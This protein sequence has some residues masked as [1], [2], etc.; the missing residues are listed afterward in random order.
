MMASVLPFIGGI[1]TARADEVKSLNEKSKSDLDMAR[2]N[3]KEAND[4]KKK[5]EKNL[6]IAKQAAA[7][8]LE[9]KKS[10]EDKLAKVEDNIKNNEKIIEKDSEIKKI[11]KEIEALGE[12]INQA[13]KEAKEAQGKVKQAEKAY[14]EAKTQS[15]DGEKFIPEDKREELKKQYED[16]DSLLTESKKSGKGIQQ[17]LDE[18]HEALK[19]LEN[20]KAGINGVFDEF[21]NSK[22]Y[23]DK[24]TSQE[25]QNFKNSK[26]S[27]IEQIDKD[28]ENIK[29][30]SEDYKRS[31]QSIGENIER[32]QKERDQKLK[33]YEKHKQAQEIQELFENDKSKNIDD[34][35]QEKQKEKLEAE[36][37]LGEAKGKT[38]QGLA[39]YQG[40]LSEED[41]KKSNIVKANAAA[42]FLE[43]RLKDNNDPFVTQNK[44][45]LISEKNI[46]QDKAKYFQSIL[47]DIEK[48]KEKKENTLEKL[49]TRESELQEDYDNKVRSLEIAR[50]LKAFLENKKNGKTKDDRLKK[51]EEV[52]KQAK[53]DLKK[54][55]AAMDELSKKDNELIVKKGKL[56]DPVDQ[57][58]LE[59]AKAQLEKDMAEVEKIKANIKELENSKELVEVKNLENKIRDLDKKIKDIKNHIFNLENPRNQDNSTRP[60]HR[61]EGSRDKNISDDLGIDLS[62]LSLEKMDKKIRLKNSYLRLK[63]SVNR[64]KEVVT[65]AENYAKTGKM[66]A[67]KRAKLIK[68][69]EKLKVNIGLVEK[70]LV[71][72]EA[73]L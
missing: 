12:Q 67:N 8:K 53:A 35:I 26:N 65:L 17:T 54:K 64:A 71:K 39:E 24:T 63:A 15:P 13:E 34:F 28:I 36:K 58:A 29:K 33:A 9:E 68:L 72:M 31:L 52:V 69:I 11:D 6:E 45:A 55:A 27:E 5:L 41:D 10:E 62:N 22:D 32:E 59:T 47:E 2:E 43:K 70:H 30:E 21:E 48:D 20:K 60:D 38:E 40:V 66:D 42:D 56:G 3:L 50:E 73:S 61:T 51:L 46:Y 37:K 49:N 16:A 23:K 25:Y 18:K 7:E 1:E 57:N 19:N 44:D 14:E 4:K